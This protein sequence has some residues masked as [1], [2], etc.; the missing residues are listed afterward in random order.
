[1]AGFSGELLVGII[2]R[3]RQ[4]LQG[5]GRC[6]ELLDESV[7]STLFATLHRLHQPRRSP[8]PFVFPYLIITMGLTDF[9][10]WKKFQ[11]VEF[12]V[13]D[14]ETKGFLLDHQHPT[15]IATPPSFVWR[16]AAC[17]HSWL[18]TFV[19]SPMCWHSVWFLCGEMKHIKNHWIK[20]K[21]IPKNSCTHCSVCVPP[22]W[23]LSSPGSTDAE[24]PQWQNKERNHSYH[25]AVEKKKK[26]SLGVLS[27]MLA[28]RVSGVTAEKK[29]PE[30]RVVSHSPLFRPPG[31]YCCT[32]AENETFWDTFCNLFT[33]LG[34]KVCQCTGR[35][36]LARADSVGKAGANKESCLK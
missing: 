34:G 27:S 30:L 23:M 26:K 31:G 17:Q 5:I 12:W 3:G 15:T 16:R 22:F 8:T 19:H 9:F 2:T 21:D 20:G 4:V 7:L 29:R 28:S 13:Q 36:R 32:L 6:W 33:R 10:V 11:T 18:F 1:M 24:R 35:L 25:W 14:S